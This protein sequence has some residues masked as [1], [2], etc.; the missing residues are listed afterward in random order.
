MALSII[1]ISTLGCMG[2]AEFS[3][4]M[5]HDVSSLN[6]IFWES[7]EDC[8]RDTGEACTYFTNDDGLRSL[9]IRDAIN[10]T[11][12]ENAILMLKACNKAN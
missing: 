12:A 11:W 10:E 5:R 4:P 7:Q 6:T 8:I 9:A 3:I 1:L 2:T